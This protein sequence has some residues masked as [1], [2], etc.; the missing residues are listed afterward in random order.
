MIYLQKKIGFSSVQD[1]NEKIKQQYIN[2]E[3]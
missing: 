2:I 3:I 1:M